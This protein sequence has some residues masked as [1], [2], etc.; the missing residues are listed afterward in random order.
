MCSGV[1][2]QLAQLL[3][4]SS[5]YDADVADRAT[6]ILAVLCCDEAARKD[7]VDRGA[8]SALVRVLVTATDS[9]DSDARVGAVKALMNI[10]Q[11]ETKE[12][13]EVEEAARALAEVC[14]LEPEDSC[15]SPGQE[16]NQAAQGKRPGGGGGNSLRSDPA[17]PPHPPPPPPPTISPTRVPTVHSLWCQ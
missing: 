5:G 2:G 3:D 15:P 6:E 11:G 13:K 12:R 17:R 1:A 4:H 9:T 14:T 10:T 16:A 8:V 7:A